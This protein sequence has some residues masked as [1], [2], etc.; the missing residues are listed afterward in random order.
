MARAATS[1]RTTKTN[2]NGQDPAKD[3]EAEITALREDISAITATLGDIAKHRT[4]EAKAEV[5]RAGRKVQ[6]K[7][8]EAVETVQENFEHAEDEIKTMIRDKPIASV[9]VAA[10]VGYLLSKVLRV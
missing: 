7:G 9:L 1:S 4:K 5:E 3:L 8:E 6:A 2:G 10:G